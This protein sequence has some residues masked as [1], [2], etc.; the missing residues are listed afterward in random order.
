MVRA[1]IWA[2]TPL[3]KP[4]GAAV[5]F[6]GQVIGGVHSEPERHGAGVEGSDPGPA[7][8]FLLHVRHQIEGIALPRSSSRHAAQ[9]ARLS[10][11]LRCRVRRVYL[12]VLGDERRVV[13]DLHA[14]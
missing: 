12:L 2:E 10:K 6:L 14:G 11:A 5:F 4:V 13:A 3:P 8:D 7:G 1:S 9:P